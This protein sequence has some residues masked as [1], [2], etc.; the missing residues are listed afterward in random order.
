MQRFLQLD[1][2]VLRNGQT[3]SWLA[4]VTE[5][6]DVREDRGGILTPP[7]AGDSGGRGA[8]AIADDKEGVGVEGFCG[9]EGSEGLRTQ[10]N[11]VGEI[12]DG[13]ARAVAFE[14]NLGARGEVS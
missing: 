5:K 4:S 10:L 2:S 12:G 9:L 8:L 7:C 3:T 14:R 1:P 6:D 13:G 11:S